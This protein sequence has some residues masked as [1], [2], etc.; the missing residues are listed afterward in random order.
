MFERAMRSAWGRRF[1]SHSNRP[2]PIHGS[3]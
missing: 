3:L 1:Y 2:K